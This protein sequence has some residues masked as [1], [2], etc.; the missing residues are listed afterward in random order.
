MFASSGRQIRQKRNRWRRLNGRLEEKRYLMG[1]PQIKRRWWEPDLADTSNSSNS[2]AAASFSRRTIMHRGA[3][4]STAT[5]VRCVRE[6]MD[7]K[8]TWRLESELFSAT[9]PATPWKPVPFP[10]IVIPTRVSH[11]EARSLK[12]SHPINKKKKRFP[13]TLKKINRATYHI[14]AGY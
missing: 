1:E 11:P 6:L 2:G 10:Y 5:H 13:R 12:R 4:H 3:P 7:N 14:V 9:F 8:V